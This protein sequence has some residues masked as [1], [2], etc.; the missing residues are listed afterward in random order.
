VSNAPLVEASAKPR[1][2]KKKLIEYA[3]FVGLPGLLVS[4]VVF[5]W[6]YPEESATA[7]A[8]IAKANA[9]ESL[10]SQ[11][12]ARFD[13]LR[14]AFAETRR[15]NEVLHRCWVNARLRDGDHL[16]VHG[17]LEQRAK[18]T[19][20]PV[21][22]KT[23]F[24]LGQ[25]ITVL[26]DR[27]SDDPLAASNGLTLRASPR[28][29]T[30][31][32]TPPDPPI[33]TRLNTTSPSPLHLPPYQAPLLLPEHC[34][35]WVE[36]MYRS[37]SCG[38]ERYKAFSGLVRVQ[39]NDISQYIPLVQNNGGEKS[40]DD[41]EKGASGSNQ[42][43]AVRAYL[44]ASAKQRHVILDL[45]K[46]ARDRHVEDLVAELGQVNDGFAALVAHRP[47]TATR[48]PAHGPLAIAAESAEAEI[49]QSLSDNQ[50]VTAAE[51]AS[52]REKNAALVW[53]RSIAP[54]AL[55]LVSVVWVFLMIYYRRY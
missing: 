35:D 47:V 1:E 10:L 15:A 27:Q 17:F 48:P 21:S 4:I 37:F 46:H 25:A 51:T 24:T 45:L 53:L 18:N 11:E 34:P 50:P 38:L 31:A 40:N 55:V 12:Q 2:G 43:T 42:S 13:R 41:E 44:K 23:T 22:G 36:Y 33:R 32:P 26:P 52:H 16:T 39:L 14:K 5:L 29:V 6:N 28:S 3:I 7:K 20:P 8:A 19:V 9:G 30:E 49:K 54:A